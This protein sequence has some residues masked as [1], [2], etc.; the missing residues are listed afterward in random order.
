MLAVLAS[1]YIDATIWKNVGFVPIISLPKRNNFTIAVNMNTTEIEPS[2]ADEPTAVE[3]ATID[4][5]FNPIDR[6]QITASRIVG[7]VLASIVGVGFVIGLAIA[8][9]VSGLGLAW[10]CVA[11]GGLL[12]TLL[13][14]WL[15]FYWPLYEY[16]HTS[17]RL[18]ETGLEIRRGVIWRH[19]ISIPV[20]RV[21]HA[22]VSQGPLQRSYELGT[23]T[24]HTAGTENAS[25]GLEG[26]SHEQA[27]QLR[28]QIVRQRKLVDVV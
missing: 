14:F 3:P 24:I 19:Q 10:Y 22:D 26:I 18:D 25:I 21:Q 13:L 9:F 6:R 12:F 5:Q 28:D 16:E 17:W 1:S 23:L 11:G 20:A 15:G 4:E 8:F 27:I 2:E 7:L